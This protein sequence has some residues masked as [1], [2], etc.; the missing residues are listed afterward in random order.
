MGQKLDLATIHQQ[1]DSIK[2]YQNALFEANQKMETHLK[3]IEE[4]HPKTADEFYN[5]DY[6]NIDE[7]QRQLPENTLFISYTDF[8]FEEKYGGLILAIGSETHRVVKT[9]ILGLKNNIE[10]FYELTQDPFSFQKTIREEFI[11]L[12]HQLYKMLIEPIEKELEGKTKLMV[13]LEG[14]LFHFPFELLLKSDEKKAYKDLDFL[15]KKYEVNY[16]YSAT[17]YLKL[18][19][20][21][22]PKDN[23]FLGFAPVFESG[24][25]F[26][27]NTRSLDFMKDSIYR[28]IN[29]D[30]FVALINTQKE[31]ETIAGLLKNRSKGTIKTF[32]QKEAT[33]TNL[34]QYLD[35]QPYQFIHIATHGLVNYKNPKL[36]ALAC[37]SDNEKSEELLYANEIQFKDINADLVVLSS[38]ESGI[39][40]LVVGEGLIALNRSF[41]YAGAKNVLFSLWKV[42]DKY[43]SQLMIEFYKNYLKGQSYTTALRNAKLKML[44][45]PASALPKHWGAF[46]LMGE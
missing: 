4:S 40:Q 27:E 23:S 11:D 6:V 44:E 42:S 7:L 14:E 28:G 18:R 25:R 19:E 38:C 21:P 29:K 16:H 13:I 1:E 9:D 15:L 34:T 22:T 46:V 35:Y 24:S 31:I 3:E 2:Y 45:T 36:S 8:S 41:I 10:K 5:N 26:S 43:S 12:S 30:G 32:V 17:A 33:K 39:G 37:H 20:K